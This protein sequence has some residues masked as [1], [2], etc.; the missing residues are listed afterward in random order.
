MINKYVLITALGSLLGP[1]SLGLA[2]S[3]VNESRP[4]DAQGAVEIYNVAGTINVQGWDKAEVEVT[5]TIGKDVERVEVTGGGSHTAVRVVLHSSH[6]WNSDG[7]AN[8]QVHVPAGSSVSCQTVSADVKVNAVRGEATL[9]TVS[10]D[11]SA[12]VGGD[13]SAHAV[14]GSVRVKAAAAKSIEVDTV[15][16]DAEVFGGGGE[17]EV[18][19]VSGDAK[20]KLGNVTRARFQTVSGTMTASMNLSADGRIDAQSVSGDVRLEFPTAPAADYD[21]Q[22]FSGNIDNCFGPK[23]NESRHGSGS[24]LNFKNGEGA[25]RVRINTHSGTIRL[26]AK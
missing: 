9:K 12:E 17:F 4:A 1:W 2:A 15:S 22:T 19:T 16:G 26:C 3:S 23:P 11:I 25:A 7:E 8:L 10:G 21:L 20:A 5:G 24:S 18:T 14:S 6:G 13:V